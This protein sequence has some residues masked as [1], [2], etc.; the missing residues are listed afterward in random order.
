M[1]TGEGECN[2]PNVRPCRWCHRKPPRNVELP[3]GDDVNSVRRARG[4]C[5]C[6]VTPHCHALSTT[7]ECDC[8]RVCVCV[9]VDSASDNLRRLLPCQCVA[10]CLHTG[11]N[12][13]PSPVACLDGRPLAFPI[14]RAAVGT[15]G[16]RS[17]DMGR[18]RRRFRWRCHRDG[19]V[20]WMDSPGGRRGRGAAEQCPVSTYTTIRE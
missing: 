18:R 19:V 14:R 5:Q 3:M 11:A 13:R 9:C 10:A 8:V 12:A 20:R 6:R 17:D 7:P 1:S 16:V 15:G 4:S 2:S